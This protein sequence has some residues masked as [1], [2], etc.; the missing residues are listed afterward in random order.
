MPPVPEKDERSD[1]Q[2]TQHWLDEFRDLQRELDRQDR[3]QMPDKLPPPSK[4]S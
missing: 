4:Q 1:P 3:P 2:D